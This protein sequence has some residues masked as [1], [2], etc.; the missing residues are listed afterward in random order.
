LTRALVLALA[1]LAACSGKKAAA[2]AA[3]D[4][5]DGGGSGS[6]DG[7]GS[8]V[9]A[10]DAAPLLSPQ[11]ATLPGT[12]WFIEDGQ[13]ARTW[14]L[15]AGAKKALGANLFPSA[16]R[17]AGKQVVIESAGTGDAGSERLVLVDDAGGRSPIGEPG[18]AVRDP[19]VDPAGKWI[20]VAANVDDHS[21]LFRIDAARPERQVRI[22]TNPEGNFH[23]TPIGP[24]SVAFASSRDGDSEIYRAD[25][26][27]KRV[28]RLTAFHK[29]DWAPIASPDGKTIAFQSDREGPVRLFLMAADGTGQ[30]RLT[31][32]TEPDRDEVQLAWSA[33]GARV[34]YV[35]EKGEA[36]QVVLH[37]LADGVA[38]VVTPDDAADT[39]P[40]FSPDGAWLVV[41]RSRKR[42]DGDEHELWALPLAGNGPQVRLTMSQ[43]TEGLPRWMP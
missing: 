10:V 3:R 39:E 35:V 15:R 32:R 27:G 36:K 34:A 33:D 25:V 24:R 30:R 26:D 40:A 23:P 11:I 7:S 17:F 2:P 37:Q 42:A 12:I 31:D 8:A 43:A 16:S 4:A 6:G 1:L 29:D 22:T 9:A 28:Q 5:G 13:P 41:A 19:A 38:R 18:F 21:E 20:V 14:R